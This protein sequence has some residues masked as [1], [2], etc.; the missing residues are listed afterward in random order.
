MNLIP[1]ISFGGTNALPN[2]RGIGGFESRYPFH[3]ENP[4]YD[5]TANLTKVRGNHNMKAGI[6]I[7]RVLRP[8]SRQSAFNGTLSFNSNTNT[9]NDTNFGFANALMGI[10]ETYQEANAH[11]FA[12]GRFNEVEFFAQDNWRLRKNFTVDLGIRFVHIG[13]T[14]VAGQ[15][16]AYFDPTKYDP[17]KAPRLYTPVCPGGAATCQNT[18]RIAQNP[19]TGQI[20]DSTYLGKLVPGSGDFY[21]GIVLADGTPP[22]FKNKAFYPSPRAGFA[23]DP[24]GDGQTAIRGGFGVNRDRYNDDLI[25][26]LIQ[27]PPLLQ[28]FTATRTTLPQLLSAPLQ[29]GTN[30]GLQAFSDFKPSTVYNWSAGVQRALPFKLTGDVAYVG[31]TNRNTA[32]NIPLNDLSPAQL[33]DPAN[34]DPTQSN[35]AGVTT[36]RKD[37]DYLR[38]Y[39]GFGG[40]NERRYF[41]DGVTYH[42]IQVSLTRRLSQGFSGTFAYTGTRSRGLR[43]WDWY[44]TDADNYARNTTAAGSRPHNLVF[45]YN[46]MIPGVS[47]FLGSYRPVK[48]ALDGWQLSGITQMT[49]GTR[50][51]FGYSFTGAPSQETLTGGLGGSRVVL[52]CDPNLPRNERTFTRQFRTECIRPPGPLTDAADTLYQ[53]SSLGDEWVSLGFVNHDITLFKNFGFAGGRNLRVQVEAYNAF[54]LTQYSNVNTNAQFDFATGN[55]TNANFGSI[56]GVRGNSNRIVQLGV[57]FTF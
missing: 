37:T 44:R 1:N 45:S 26:A 34:L 21:N 13:P 57:R 42:S 43:N 10:V 55:Q 6:F 53:G 52:T 47:R 29:Q 18:Q 51:G 39:A 4:T 28:T 3:A 16:V 54:N 33:L 15:Q 22:Q 7:E 14:Y 41:K 40:I 8:A 48:A 12:E 11:P 17:A 56:T 50:G 30:G 38:Q 23:W 20:L 25:L 31:N 24:K 9:P 35:A 36:T 27:A 49:G 2:T 46:Y 19:L 5:I 32:R